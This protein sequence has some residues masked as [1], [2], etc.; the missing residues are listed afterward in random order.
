MHFLDDFIKPDSLVFDI[1]ANIG[2]MTYEM[3]LLNPRKIISVEPQLV[4]VNSLRERFKDDS[5]VEILYSAVSD[6]IGFAT[7]YICDNQN[8]VSSIVKEW[9]TG[10]FKDYFFDRTEQVPVVTLD[11][12]IE[13]YGTPDFI[14]IDAEGN[15]GTIVWALSYPIKALSFEYTAETSYDMV[16]AVNRLSML[17][18]YQYGYTVSDVFCLKTGWRNRDEIIEDVRKACENSGM[19]GNVY[20]ML[21]DE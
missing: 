20:A 6:Y 18:D 16:N 19:F 9:Q 15:D 5:R 17:G 2:Q 11:S 7:L 3:L 12:M 13:H 4:C 10:R 1:G 21:S 14:K 8:T